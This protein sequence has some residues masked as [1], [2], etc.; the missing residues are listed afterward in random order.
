M[1]VIGWY[2]NKIEIYQTSNNVIQV[3][4]R[5][6]YHWIEKQSVIFV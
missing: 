2:V 3:T 6:E 4:T 5:Y 1:I